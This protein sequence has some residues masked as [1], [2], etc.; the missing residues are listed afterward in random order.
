[1]QVCPRSPRIHAWGVVTETDMEEISGVTRWDETDPA[2]N[3]HDRFRRSLTYEVNA[4]I[5]GI[6]DAG[7]DDFAI[8]D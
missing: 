8:K 5:T 1:M 3:E 6:A 4:A 7:T 2:H